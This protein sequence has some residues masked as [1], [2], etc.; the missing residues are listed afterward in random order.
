MQGDDAR[1]KEQRQHKPAAVA[2]RK[3]VG[4]KAREEGDVWLYCLEN[5]FWGGFWGVEMQ[6]TGRARNRV[7]LFDGSET[8]HRM[9]VQ[10]G[11]VRSTGTFPQFLQFPWKVTSHC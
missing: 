10:R 5:G 9:Q 7:E 2:A 4:Q 1:R 11:E 8:K 3:A 6:M